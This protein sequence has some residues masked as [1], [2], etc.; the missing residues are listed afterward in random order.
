MQIYK[1]DNA[2]RLP[3]VPHANFA[4]AGLTRSTLDS[5]QSIESPSALTHDREF[6]QLSH[7]LSEYPEVRAELVEQARAAVSSGEFLTRHAAEET[8]ARFL[9]T[10][11]SQVF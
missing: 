5:Q 6:S 9:S 10:E 4:A 7:R 3:D 1:Q 8:A 11:A 2:V